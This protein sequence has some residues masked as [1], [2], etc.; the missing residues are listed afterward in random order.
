MQV[1]SFNIKNIYI[2]VLES[3]LEEPFHH[4]FHL[5]YYTI[6]IYTYKYLKVCFFLMWDKYLF[7]Y[8]FIYKLHQ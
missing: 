4:D 5:I 7:I 6:K 2:I 1:T 3:S 8:L